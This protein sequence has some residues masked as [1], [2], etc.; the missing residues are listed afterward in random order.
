MPGTA[1]QRPNAAG[2]SERHVPSETRRRQ[3]DRRQRCGRHQDLREETRVMPWQ[4]L[5]QEPYSARTRLRQQVGIVAKKRFILVR[6]HIVTPTG[7]GVNMQGFISMCQR[8][9]AR[10]A[11]HTRRRRISIKSP[12]SRDIALFLSTTTTTMVVGPCVGH[13]EWPKGGYPRK[14]SHTVGGLRS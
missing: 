1:T 10:A 6:F 12:Y 14:N 4:R 7:L 9:T 13:S 8:A 5:R 3:Q 11:I 2:Q